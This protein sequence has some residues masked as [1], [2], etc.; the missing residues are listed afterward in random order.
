MLID[1][2]LTKNTAPIYTNCSILFDV[3]FTIIWADINGNTIKTFEP[4][5]YNQFTMPQSN[6]DAI[7]KG[8]RTVVEKK[9]YFNELT[10]NVAGKTGTAEESERRPNHAL[11]VGYAPF[12][13]PEIA[14]TARSPYGYSS[15]CA[16]PVTK[17]VIAYYYGLMDEEDLVTGTADELEAGVS[18]N[19]I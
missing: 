6:W 15:D 13:A 11:F 5:I 14:I 2:I 4:V 10:V 16:A 9:P 17:D 19:E 8:M 3:R 12:E 18:N 1:R 7:H